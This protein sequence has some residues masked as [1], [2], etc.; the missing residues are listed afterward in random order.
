MNA[1][2]PRYACACPDE[3][4]SG[5]PGRRGVLQALA[6]GALAA[7]G[8]AL[9]GCAAP[10]AGSAP[11][12]IDTHHHFYPPE[13]Q[14]AWLDWEDKRNI[15]H[16]TQQVGWSVQGALA[17]MDAAGVR[18]AILSIASTP[19]VWFDWPAPEVARIVRACNDFGAGMVRDHPGRFGLFAT[20]PMIDV[21]ATLKEIAYVL[22]VLKVVAQKTMAEPGMREAMDKLSLGYSYGDDAAFRQTMATNNENFKALI[23]KLNLK[24]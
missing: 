1:P 11:G 10:A 5:N 18:T 21:D 8:A 9:P 16:F 4:C 3:R 14:K 7:A 20:L 22:D 17:D 24:P 12:L 23:P 19:G 13:Y 2:G 6:L 15:P